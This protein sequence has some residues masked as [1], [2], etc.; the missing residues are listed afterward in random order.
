[1][2]LQAGVPIHER[3]LRGQPFGEGELRAL[4]NGRPPSL[5]YARRGRQNKTL[6]IDPDKLTDDELL[7]LMAREPALI[8]RPTLIVDGEIIPGPSRA[9]LDE[10]GRRLGSGAGGQEPGGGAQLS[11]D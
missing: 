8:R 6:G 2:L 4:L 1:V 11:V 3:D 5:I 7:A 10:L 9:Q